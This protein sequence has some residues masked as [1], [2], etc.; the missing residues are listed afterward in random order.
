M[1]L[2]SLVDEVANEAD[3]FLATVEGRK[4]TREAIADYVSDNYPELSRKE[5]N[6]VVNGVINILESDDFFGV[7]HEEAHHRSHGDIDDD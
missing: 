6:V 1:N 5:H 3:S 2:N 7:E 4:E